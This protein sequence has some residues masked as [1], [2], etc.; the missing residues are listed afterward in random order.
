MTTA[1]VN[2]PRWSAGAAVRAETYANM[3]LP[4]WIAVA[5]ATGLG[6]GTRLLDIA[7]GSGEFCR[8]AAGRRATVSGLDAAEG[9]IKIARRLV[10]DGDFRVGPMEKLPW[11]DGEFDLVTGFNAFQ[12]AADM[13]GALAEAR[14]VTRAGGQVAICN[15][16]R[17]RSTRRR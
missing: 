13:V 9:M 5:D 15:W 8:L 10:P 4:A 14:R 17:R 6:D 3:S 7:C 11:R 1:D 16:G 2:G 12:M